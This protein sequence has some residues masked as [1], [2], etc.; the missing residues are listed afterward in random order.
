[1]I[2]SSILIPGI[3]LDIPQAQSVLLQYPARFRYRW[4][5]SVPHLFVHERTDET[6]R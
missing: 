1:M 2:S 3:G 6:F 4:Q 5:S